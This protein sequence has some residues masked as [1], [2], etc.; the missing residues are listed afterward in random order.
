MRLKTLFQPKQIWALAILLAGLLLL[1]GEIINDRFWMHD[2]EVYYRTAE[3]M[4]RGGE[5]YRIA[6][7]GHYV[8]KYSPTAGLYFIPFTLLPFM[9]AKTMYWLLLVLLAIAVLHTLFQLTASPTQEYTV[10]QRNTVLL[11]S[12]LAVGAHVH[13]EWHLGQVNFVLLALYVC[14]V[15]LWQRKRPVAAGVVLAASVFIKPFGFIL[16]PYLLLKKRFDILASTAVAI[17]LLGL[18]PFFLYPSLDAFTALYKGWFQELVIEMSAKQELLKS[19]NHTIFSVLARYTPIQYLLQSEAAI[20]V[21]QLSVLAL[22]GGFVLYFVQAG[23]RLKQTLLADVAL[24]VA[25]IPLFAVT[26]LNAFLFTLPCIVLLLCRFYELH[27]VARVLTVAGCVLVGINI[28]D[29]MGGDLYRLLESLSVY[30]F[31]T[32]ALLAALTS[33]RLTQS[34]RHSN[35]EEQ[36]ERAKVLEGLLK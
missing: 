24:L 27:K 15:L 16:L 5:I 8:Y 18:L 22:I 23:A 19:G 6:S 26:S 32:L 12:F 20:K 33:L 7:D 30:T 10:K 3:R 17:V 25:L 21:Y 31:G 36:P 29:L 4:L 11:L 14:V 34:R 28:R 1:L 35:T 13:R 9:A 2:L